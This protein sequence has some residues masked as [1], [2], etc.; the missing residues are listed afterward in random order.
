M[1]DVF[2]N[3]ECL[4]TRWI[5]SVKTKQ[6]SSTT[7]NARHVSFTMFV[8]LLFFFMC[9]SHTFCL[10]VFFFKLSNLFSKPRSSLH[11][12]QTFAII[13]TKRPPL[14]SDLSH[15]F[16]AHGLSFLLLLPVLTR[17]HPSKKMKE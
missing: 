17:G 5:H 1:D 2:V 15:P 14:L 6:T 16:A 4:S 9:L 7:N 10:V 13:F 8:C 3:H 12:V 11:T